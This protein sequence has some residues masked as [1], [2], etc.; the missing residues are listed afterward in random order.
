MIL[1]QIQTVEFT[2]ESKYLSFEVNVVFDRG[3]KVFCLLN[4]KTNKS[5]RLFRLFFLEGVAEVRHNHEVDLNLLLS[6][7][8]FEF[9]GAPILWNLLYQDFLESL[10]VLANNL[11]DWKENRE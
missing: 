11:N 4:H 3:K 6:I 7:F 2:H 9:S 8:R 10:F 5:H 1:A